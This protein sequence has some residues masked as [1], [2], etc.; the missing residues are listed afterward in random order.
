M[1]VALVLLLI[2]VASLLFHWLTPWWLTPLASNWQRMDDT[3][4]V[5]VLITGAFFVAI[6][7]FLIYT[8]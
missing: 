4:T 6:M 2:V 1:A 7:L 5:T 3:L 8:V